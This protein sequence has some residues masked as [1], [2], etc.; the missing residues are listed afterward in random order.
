MMAL[1]P[2]IIETGA[3]LQ[4]VAITSYCHCNQQSRSTD[5]QAVATLHEREDT[6]RQ[7]QGERRPAY[8]PDSGG[9]RVT[10]S[11]S[12]RGSSKSPLRSLRTMTPA[13]SSGTFSWRTS[14][15][16]VA[17]SGSVYGNTASPLGEYF[18]R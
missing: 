7:A 18:S 16:T 13:S 11:P 6:L 2:L 14:V 10:R 15:W 17:A 9:I 1:C 12:W 8:P 4:R 3:L 5:V